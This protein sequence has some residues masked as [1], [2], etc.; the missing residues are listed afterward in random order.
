MGDCPNQHRECKRGV[1]VR[2]TMV[3]HPLC[4]LCD[5]GCETSIAAG[6][7]LFP[8]VPPQQATRT[9]SPS[10]EVLQLFQG[11]CEA[12]ALDV[13]DDQGLIAIKV[14][15]PPFGH[16]S[17]AIVASPLGFPPWLLACPG[18]WKV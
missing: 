10:R 7:A 13:E 18:M 4:E 16:P 6:T 17:S 5:H 14:S 1:E 8:P 11:L 12:G 3:G 2:E 15:K 9:T